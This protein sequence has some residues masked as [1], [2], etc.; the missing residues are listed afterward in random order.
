[1]M[2]KPVEYR[3]NKIN[4]LPFQVH[5][6]IQRIHEFKRKI[7]SH[8]LCPFSNTHDV[9]TKRYPF[10]LPDFLPGFV[11]FRKQAYPLFSKTGLSGCN[12][13]V[14]TISDLSWG[15]EGI[16]RIEGK[17]VFIPFSLPG[18]VVEV[19]IVQSKKNYSQG[20][21]VR[22]LEPS[23]DRVEPPCPFYRECG[24]CQLQHLALQRQV[25]EKERLFKQTLEHFLKP[26][27]VLVLPTL[28]SP[29]AFGY[30]HRL[31]L[32]TSWK[33]KQFCLGFFRPKSHDLV[34]LDCCL[35]ANDPSNEVLKVLPEKMRDLQLKKW[36]PDI[37]LQVHEMPRRGG[38]V[39]TFPKGLDPSQKKRITK[40][41]L[42]I[43]GINYLLFKESDCLPLTGEHPFFFEKESPEYWLPAFETGLPKDLRL[44][45]FP[46]VFTQVNLELNRRLIARLLSLNL[47][48][49]QDTVLDLYCGL[50]N[51]SLPVAM[52]AQEVVGIE[53]FPPA[54]TNARWNGKIN[55]ISNCTFIQARVEEGLN[56][57]KWSAKPVSWIILDPPRTG[58]L[59]VIPMLDAWNIK[60]V[61]YISCDPMTLFRDLTQLVKR[62]WGIKWSQP[63]DFFPQTF[64]LESITFLTK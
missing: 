11:L 1:M 19:K 35:L 13:P 20:K 40:E 43:Q 52:K 3:Y 31:Q 37:E 10:N 57:L 2:E 41:L 22:I 46:L 54:V 26:K 50:G 8:S 21:L 58:A 47:F 9:F 24:G 59:E 38:I 14:V 16:G 34:P 33:N 7:K 55:Q 39:F 12:M 6:R 18:E 25:Q 63:V 32:K 60:G 51:F 29:G 23:P 45:C 15:G 17:V 53:A 49:R 27:K 61:L 5:Q 4:L 30:R 28:Q 42:P 44:T 62:G 36:A 64:H 48:D 56:Q